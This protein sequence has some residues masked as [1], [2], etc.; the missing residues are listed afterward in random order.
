ML[1]S[2]VLQLGFMG[3]PTL[4]LPQTFISELHVV[5]HCRQDALQ[6]DRRIMLS[7]L[8]FNLLLP[9]RVK[10]VPKHARLL[11][12]RLLRPPII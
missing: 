1:F 2:L 12:P 8:P 10:E 6:E 4:V 7:W 5:I 9:N 11:L 3:A